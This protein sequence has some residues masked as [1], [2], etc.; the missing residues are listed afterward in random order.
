MYKQF[1]SPTDPTVS[2]SRWL[3]AA[4][5]AMLMQCRNVSDPQSS[6]RSL[7][8]ALIDRNLQ[9]LPQPQSVDDYHLRSQYHALKGSQNELEWFKTTGIRDMATKDLGTDLKRRD[10]VAAHGSQEDKVALAQ[11]CLNS[12]EDKNWATISM[13]VN[14]SLE[15]ADQAL[16]DQI[17]QRL[18]QLAQ[19]K[20]LGKERGYAL[21]LLLPHKL[22]KSQSK[23]GSLK[24]PGGKS[25]VQTFG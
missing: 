10:V 18:E 16:L 19:D 21:G 8:L 25:A 23:A 17:C 22:Q 13:A 14:L 20:E 4:I 2:D 11:E 6:E 3:Q 1:K 24:A 5:Q 15:L 12:M 7:L 9:S